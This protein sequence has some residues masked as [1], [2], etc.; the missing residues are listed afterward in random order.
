MPAQAP[1]TD[2]DADELSQGENSVLDHLHVGGVCPPGPPGMAALNASTVGREIIPRVRHDTAWDLIESA[3]M[4][5]LLFKH[6]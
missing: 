1:G 4:K 2:G 3:D 5:I 6:T